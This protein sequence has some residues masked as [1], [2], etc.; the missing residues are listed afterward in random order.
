MDDPVSITRIKED[1]DKNLSGY[2]YLNTGNDH[3]LNFVNLTLAVEIQDK[4][5]HFS[6]PAVFPLAFNPRSVQQT[7]PAGVFQE[8]DLGPI[9]VTLRSSDGDHDGNFE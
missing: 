8:K 4:T 6:G 3:P 2:F 9:L 1:D 5:G 7:P